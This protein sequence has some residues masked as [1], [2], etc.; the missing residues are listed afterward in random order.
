MYS[1]DV[2]S[3]IDIPKHHGLVLL[4]EHRTD[5]FSIYVLGG[6]S[7]HCWIWA[8]RVSSKITIV[9][10]LH[11]S[12]HAEATGVPVMRARE[13]NPNIQNARPD[14]CTCRRARWLTGTDSG[15]VADGVLI[16][17]TERYLVTPYTNT[18]CTGYVGAAKP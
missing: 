18:G 9:S 1:V 14:P 12:E 7:L 10:Q 2:K 8:S 11:I 15:V 16:P 13:S 3:N 4:R 6:S 5:S 17:Y